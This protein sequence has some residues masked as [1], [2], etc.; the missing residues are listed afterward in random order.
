MRGEFNGFFIIKQ[1]ENRAQSRPLFLWIKK[2]YKLI[3][4]QS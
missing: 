1:I 2:I 4:E 3:R